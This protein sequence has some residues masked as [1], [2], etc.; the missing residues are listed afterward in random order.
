MRILFSIHK[1]TWQTIGRVLASIILVAIA[2][3]DAEIVVAQEA[4]GQGENAKAAMPTVS[5]LEELK[6]RI[7]AE[8]LLRDRSE[9]VHFE[10]RAAYYETLGRLK[11]KSQKALNKQARDFLNNRWK[12]SPFSNK[13][14]QEFPRYVDLFK[15]PETYHGEVITLRGHAQR[16]VKTPAGENDFGIEHL[17][18]V[19]M[20]TED[21]QS[22]PA[23]VITPEIPDDVKVGDEITDFISVTGIFFK[24]Y[25]YDAQDTKRFAPMILAARLTR[26]TGTDSTPENAARNRRTTLMFVIPLLFLLVIAC[27]AGYFWGRA[28]TRHRMRGFQLESIGDEPPALEVDISVEPTDTA[29]VPGSEDQPTDNNRQRALDDEKQEPKA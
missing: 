8:V 17:Y 26:Q 13:S 19:W 25:T 14:F 12:S 2:V 16:V 24:F 3:P 28:G 15:N 22:N 18:E 11:Q 7:Q 6:E 29:E 4:N 5:T 23:V 20:Y 9:G 21:S 10:E 1:K 27:F